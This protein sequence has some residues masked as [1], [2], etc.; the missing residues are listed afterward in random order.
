M[1]TSYASA[2]ARWCTSAPVASHTSAIA[3][4]YEIF[5]ARNEFAATF[6]SSAVARSMTTTCAPSEMIGA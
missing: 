6:T 4:M 2:V 3:L 1:R 5:V